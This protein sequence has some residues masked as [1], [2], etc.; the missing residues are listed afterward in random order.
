[1]TAMTM[2]SLTVRWS[3]AE[4][5]EGVEEQLATYVE[6]TSHARFTGMSGPALQDVAGP[7]R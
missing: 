2:R 1:M 5:P 4:A 6:T 7:A 3:L